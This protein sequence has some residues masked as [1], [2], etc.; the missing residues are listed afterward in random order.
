MSQLFG[1][2]IDHKHKNNN[3]SID[4][5]HNLIKNTLGSNYEVS[6]HGSEENIFNIRNKITC[7]NNSEFKYID[8]I[9]YGTF[10]WVNRKSFVYREFIGINATSEYSIFN[11][12]KDEMI[13]LIRHYFQ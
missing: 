13:S 11:P 8:S 10:P 2:D 3:M 4:F 9:D 1:P 12:T 7:K 5:V 6:L